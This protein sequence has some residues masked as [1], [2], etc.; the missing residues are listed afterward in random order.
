MTAI[1]EGVIISIPRALR[2]AAQARVL[3][4]LAKDLP[5]L[6]QM[7]KRK[8]ALVLGLVKQAENHFRL[9]DR[10]PARWDGNADCRR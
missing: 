5:S 3:S 7:R 2:Q 4:E 8:R 9:A 1:G 6:G 10:V